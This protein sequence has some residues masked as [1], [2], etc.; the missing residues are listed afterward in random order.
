MVEIAVERESQGKGYGSY[1][2]LQSLLH[3]K[4]DGISTVTLTVDPNNLRARHLYCEKFGFEFAEYR[5]DEYGQGRD[6]L[7]LK[8]DLE[9]WKQ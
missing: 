3:L 1:L 9:N 4:K 6:R 8:L 7:F 2:L 5:K